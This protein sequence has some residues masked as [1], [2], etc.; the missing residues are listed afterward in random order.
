MN[1]K[2]PLNIILSSTII[3]EILYPLFGTLNLPVLL[4][5]LMRI[6]LTCL[7]IIIL[8]LHRWKGFFRTPINIY[9][10]WVL[11]VFV[12]N[13]I[14]GYG[15]WT[16][17]FQMFCGIIPS[18]AIFLISIYA[19]EI[20][21]VRTINTILFALYIY[22]LYS[23]LIVGTGTFGHNQEVRLGGE[24]LNANTIGIRASLIFYFAIIKYLK[25]IITKYQLFFL[26]II[27]AIAV[28][29]SGSR[30]GLAMSVILILILILRQSHGNTKLLYKPLICIVFCLGLYVIL[31]YT[32]IGQRL[33]STSEQIDSASYLQTGTFWDQLGDRGYQYYV[34]IPYIC[35]N[36]WFGIGSNNYWETIPEATNVL[37][38]EYLIQLLECGIFA[39][40]LYFFVYFW[41]IRRCLSIKTSNI[42]SENIRRLSLLMMIALLFAATVT[43]ISYYGMYSCCLGYLIYSMSQIK[44]QINN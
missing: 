33:L 7:S 38:S 9:V 40:V 8:V 3:F 21:E 34:S 31:E 39:A 32:V 19:Y 30:T 35:N 2:R 15:F 36:F 20:N 18:A 37:H 43:R 10:I 13:L 16:S 44:K 29:L 12:K 1:N 5:S 27:P 6:C 25:G 17:H 23:L 41:I 14:M 4:V 22:V 42:V 28:V 26:L 24:V 11:Y